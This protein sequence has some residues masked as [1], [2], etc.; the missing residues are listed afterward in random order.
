MSECSLVSKIQRDDDG[1]GGDEDGERTNRVVVSCC[2]HLSVQSA[3][4]KDLDWQQRL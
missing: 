4:C 1:G 3:N 2:C